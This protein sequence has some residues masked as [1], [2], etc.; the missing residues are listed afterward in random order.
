VAEDTELGVRLG[1]IGYA[2][3]YHPEALA[4]HDHLAFTA[5][6]LV[7][8]ARGYAPANFQLC[9]KH[10]WLL[11]SGTGAFGKL[12]ADWAAKTRDLL[13]QSRRQTAEWTQAIA[14]FD[15]F[16]FAPLFSQRKGEVTEAELVLRTF[17]VIVPQVHMFH[18]LDGILKVWERE[19]KPSALGPQLSASSKVVSSQPSALS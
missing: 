15:Q 16:N 5:A 9:R 6:E 13:D 2:V 17:D 11:G 12:D 3:W 1:Q 18:L 4:W 8:R 10:P 14:R 7:K 19:E